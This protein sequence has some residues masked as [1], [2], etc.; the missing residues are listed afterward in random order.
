MFYIKIIDD[1]GCLGSNSE[2]TALIHVSRD[3]RPPHSKPILRSRMRCCCYCLYVIDRKHVG[4]VGERRDAADGRGD[5]EY[6][7][8]V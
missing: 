1:K 4:M 7:H 5:G 3:L 2:L 8:P 6:L